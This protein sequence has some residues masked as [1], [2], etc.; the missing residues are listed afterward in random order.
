MK[1]LN[2]K[3]LNVTS[4]STNVKSQIIGGAEG[5]PTE[6]QVAC[7]ETEALRSCLRECVANA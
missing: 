5:G 2:L 1:K 7:P 3:D 6:H 4:F